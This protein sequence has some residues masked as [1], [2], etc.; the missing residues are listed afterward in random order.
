MTLHWSGHAPIAVELYDDQAT[1]HAEKRHRFEYREAKERIER[2]KREEFGEPQ[3]GER[4]DQGKTRPAWD[5]VPARKHVKEE[6]D[7]NSAEKADEMGQQPPGR[8]KR[9]NKVI[10][11]NQRKGAQ[12]DGGQE[13]QTV[14]RRAPEEQGRDQP[15]SKGQET[16]ENDDVESKEV[17]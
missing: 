7:A 14:V 6:D 10:I 5:K 9:A 8:G 16:R 1:Y 3:I 2:C 15:I 12:G 11:E 4:G 17:S 13:R